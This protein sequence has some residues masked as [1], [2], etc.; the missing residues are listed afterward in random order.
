MSDPHPREISQMSQVPAPRSEAALPKI[1]VTAEGKHFRVDWDYQEAPESRVLLEN[2]LLDG[3]IWGVIATLRIAEKCISCATPR[4][5][6]IKRLEE[7]VAIR[8]AELLTEALHPIVAREHQR[9]KREASWPHVR[10]A[11]E[12]AAF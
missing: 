10:Y 9:L 12:N 7:S 3:Y 4:T 5:G 6:T 2:Q 11:K 1:E 8:L